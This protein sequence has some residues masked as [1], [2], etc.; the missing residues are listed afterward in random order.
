MEIIEI[1]KH[2]VFRTKL[3]EDLN[4][5]IKFS[6]K[7]KNQQGRILSN[8]GGFQSKD[9]NLNENILQSLISE[10]LKFGNIFSKEVLCINKQ[11]SLENIWLNINYYK[12]Y[13]MVHNHPFSIISGVFY[14]K[15]PKKCGNLKFYKDTDSSSFLHQNIVYN[16]NNFNSETWKF[17]PEENMLYLFPSWYKHL[18]EQ[19]LSKQERISI[20]F[21]LI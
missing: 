11:M 15:T 13:N 16:Y 4:S 5:L 14:V 8:V 2:C 6:K 19:N 3:N 9:L 21:N 1:F 12:D 17:I 18:V 20:S 7:L 10:I